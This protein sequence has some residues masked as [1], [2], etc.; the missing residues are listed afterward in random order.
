MGKSKYGEVLKREDGYGYCTVT[1][2]C[3]WNREMEPGASTT[4]FT[5]HFEHDH[6]IEWKKFQ[7]NL[8]SSSISKSPAPKRQKLE[9]VNQ[10]Q[11]LMLD[12][13]KFSKDDQVE[14]AIM[15][16]IATDTLPI[17]TV[18]KPGFINLIKTL[19]PK[20]NLKGRKYFAQ[21][22]LPR[23]YERMVERVK[24]DVHSASDFTLTTD[25]W[26]SKNNK[27]S[28]MS[29][30]AH[31]LDEEMKPKFSLIDVMPVVGKHD[32]QNLS[33]ILTKA[34][35]KF[36]IDKSKIH[37]IVRDGGMKATTEAAGFESIWCW[38]H[39]LNRAVV[40][41]IKEMEGFKKVIEKVKRLVRK[42][43][44]SRNLAAEFANFQALLDLPEVSLKK[45]IDIRWNSLY[46]MLQCFL[47][48]KQAIISLLAGELVDEE[49]DSDSEDDA[50]D[51][52]YTE[53][54]EIHEEAIVTDAI[55]FSKAEWK[56]IQG[57]I[58][59]LKPIYDSTLFVE[60]R[61]TNA[62]YII[63][64]MKQ[65]EMDLITEPKTS[66]FP[67]V[68]KAIVDGLKSRMK[69][70]ETK[71][72]LTI[73]TIL[74]P[75]FKASLL[76]QERL[77]EY[78]DQMIADILRKT[79]TSFDSSIVPGPQLQES[80]LFAKILS[81]VTNVPP[82]VLDKKSKLLVEIENYL[83]TPFD[84]SFETSYDFWKDAKNTGSFP[85]LRLLF[86]KYGSA[87]ASSAE[88]ER[89]FSIIGIIL[90]ER[91]NRLSAETIQKLAFLHHSVLLNGFRF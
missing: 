21:V 57:M 79:N 45:C 80:H 61:S 46:L 85:D 32:A 2:A 33:T 26:S 60:R 23:V 6:P 42:L 13:A 62:G 76:P 50:D 5:Y 38:A 3:K 24:K 65:I 78:K 18:E 88:S 15:F 25:V 10:K 28:L 49:E 16:M 52:L 91:R 89:L 44:K 58:E 47:E 55:E 1:D 36:G 86:G 29:L 67:N 75:L 74:D 72:S 84:P 53:A 68:R 27:H 40:D 4:S 82:E 56:Q 64:L 7:D 70:W 43:R 69:G 39:V 48:N 71:N 37:V 19:V 59:I 87:P 12:F 73:S 11:S 22:V 83:S 90:I 81:H 9:D 14:D 77:G 34:I 54:S 20:F 41:G 30:T 51:I 17:S 31:Y 35:D 66:C 63:P 8:K